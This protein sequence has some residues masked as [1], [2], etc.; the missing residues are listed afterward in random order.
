MNVRVTYQRNIVVV[1]TVTDSKSLVNHLIGRGVESDIQE[2]ALKKQ[3]LVQITAGNFSYTIK[4]IDIACSSY[5]GASAKL[6]GATI[7]SEVKKCFK[8]EM[9]SVN[10]ILFALT[11]NQVTL[12]FNEMI[13]TLL[14][15]FTPEVKE[16]CAVLIMNCDLQNEADRLEE[17]E[18]FKSSILTK[19]L[20]AFVQERVY[21]VSFPNSSIPSIVNEDQKQ[22]NDLIQSCGEMRLCK[23]LMV[24][25]WFWNRY[26]TK[27]CPLD[28]CVIL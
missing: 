4:H 8:D 21:A 2:E 19:D 16:M 25:D 12:K 1:S 5:Y 20:A 27:Y 28:N 13:E 23:Y 6:D 18:K 15:S 3:S 7:I 10:L 26:W 9:T 22:I 14:K 17:V 24:D 11:M